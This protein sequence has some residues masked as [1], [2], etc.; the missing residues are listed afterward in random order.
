[1][2]SR[3]LILQILQVAKIMRRFFYGAPAEIMQIYTT[4]GSNFSP[5]VALDVIHP[6]GRRKCGSVVT[7]ATFLRIII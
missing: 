7:F 3:S 4:S 5:G 1:M 2:I 6:S